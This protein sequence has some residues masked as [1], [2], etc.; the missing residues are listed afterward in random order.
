[1]QTIAITLGDPGGI[2]PEVA[3]KA[4]YQNRW[5]ATLRFVLIGSRT[6]LRRQAAQLR[7]PLPPTWCLANENNFSSRIVNWEPE[8]DLK[9]GPAVAGQIFHV[10][11]VLRT[12]TARSCRSRRIAPLPPK[13][14]TDPAGL[15]FLNIESSSWPYC[16]SFERHLKWR[17]GVTGKTQ[18]QA[19]A[20]WIQAAV[21]GCMAGRFDALVTGPICKQSLRLAGLPF[22]GH[23]EFLAAL[24]GT[25]SFAMMLLGGPL[26]VVLVTRH[27]PLAKVPGAISR[28]AIQEAVQLGSQA[29][30]WL[31]VKQKTVGICALNPHAGDDG[32]LGREEITTIRPAL[33]A[34][35][36]RGLA[37]EGPVPGDVIFH[38]ALQGRYGAVVAMYHDQGLGPLKMIA[39]EEGVNLTLGLPIVRTSPDHGTAFD[40]AG[41]GVAHAGSMVA[42]IRLAAR[43]ARR[44]NPW[45]PRS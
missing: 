16:H 37:V 2:G 18:G 19:A 31:G 40:I 29:L 6:I 1:M 34:L 13:L 9:S 7:L 28:T 17:P 5:P 42:A 24:T 44:K 41:K 12:A 3:L 43:L 23:T 20:L 11:G 30:S 45:S 4:L 15:K 39:F 22:P 38:Q 14:T 26:R 32:I 33:R 8:R 35:R 27:L 25:H 10:G 36:R 21:S